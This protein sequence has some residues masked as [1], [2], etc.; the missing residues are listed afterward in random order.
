MK[1]IAAVIVVI[2]AL[3]S[4]GSA[5]WPFSNSGTTY[6][7]T[8]LSITVGEKPYESSALVYIAEDQG[9]FAKNG[10]NV[11]MRNYDSAPRAIEGLLNDEADLVLS[12]EYVSIGKA[13]NK[14]KI[15]VIGSIDKYQTA[16][17][18]GRKDKGI[19]N[20]SDLKGK[21]IGITRGGIGEF[22][23][24][25]F[26]DLHGISIRDITLVGMPPSQY[27]QAFTNGS[28][29]AIIAGHIYTDQIQERSGSNIIIWPAQNSQNTYWVISCRGDWAASH[30][31][32]I[33][34]LL[35]SLAQAEEFAIN[36]PEEAKTIVQKRLNLSDEYISTVWSDHQ[37]SLT[38]DQSLLMAMNDEGRWMIK[39]NL[40]T[41]K[42]LPYF[43]DYIYTGS[44]LF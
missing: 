9:Y 28:V 4:V 32:P 14:E 15:S 17:L 38:L 25:R 16:Y 42:T 18:A 39:N 11:T 24:G 13:F 12:S 41:E 43:R 2:I 29:D 5:A 20:I 34:R 26:L 1:T 3:V 23:L 21:K 40:T 44:S 8:P 36:H 7:G 19:E 37:F 10:L 22:Y 30:P 31:D 33:N 27:M 35:E 6:S